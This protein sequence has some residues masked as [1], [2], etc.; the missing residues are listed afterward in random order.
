MTEP[1]VKCAGL[2]WHIKMERALAAA[3]GERDALRAERDAP[4]GGYGVPSGPMRDFYPRVI[5]KLEAE[6]A[7]ARGR[8]KAL[9]EAIQQILDISQMA[10][11][12]GVGCWCAQRI[13]RMGEV[14]RAALALPYSPQATTPALRAA[15]RL[16][17]EK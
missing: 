6:A 17:G 13:P 3:E 14:A 9:R 8:E 12:W 16:G 4:M 15:G 1:L 2:D 7:E 5:A 10:G 11:V